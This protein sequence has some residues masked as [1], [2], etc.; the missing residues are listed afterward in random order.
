M[1]KFFSH[2]KVLI[3]IVLVSLFAIPKA[4]EYSNRL[5]FSR[6]F[7]KASRYAF[8]K[9]GTSKFVFGGLWSGW[10]KFYVAGIADVEMDSL[11]KEIV[12]RTSSYD[13]FRIKRI[14]SSIWNPSSKS[15][16]KEFGE[17]PSPETSYFDSSDPFGTHQKCRWKIVVS[18]SRNSLWIDVSIGTL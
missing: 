16:F 17:L 14:K 3:V 4:W 7:E 12:A 1:H 13:D 9:S 6:S 8:P 15:F 5:E 2:W 11:Q 18:P 10:A